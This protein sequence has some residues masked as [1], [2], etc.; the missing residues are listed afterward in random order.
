[1]IATS[2]DE[3]FTA[4]A[5]GAEIDNNG[6][7]WIECMIECMDGAAEFAPASWIGP[8]WWILTLAVVKNENGDV[9]TIVDNTGEDLQ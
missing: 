2:F 6:R 5:D 7:E 4:A 3:L 1:M 8:G 9:M